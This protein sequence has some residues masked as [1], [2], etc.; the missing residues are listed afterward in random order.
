ME[1][2]QKQLKDTFN[3][4]IK[5]L[6]PQKNHTESS[7][8]GTKTIKG[9]QTII[10]AEDKFKWQSTKNIYRNLNLADINKTYN[11]I[12]ARYLMDF[13]SIS[14]PP[15]TDLFLK[16]IKTYTNMSLNHVGLAGCIWT[17]D[18]ILKWFETIYSVKCFILRPQ[19]PEE[20][21]VSY[22]VTDL[23]Y[24]PDT[25]VDLFKPRIEKVAPLGFIVIVF[26]GSH[27]ETLITPAINESLFFEVGSNLPELFY[28]LLKLDEKKWKH[29]QL[30]THKSII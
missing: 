8:S 14:S 27:Y 19:E 6:I 29:F 30:M 22:L 16:C 25:N 9:T 11:I 13:C 24:F 4:M 28:K 2:F 23:N 10:T 5:N 21:H 17:D 20:Y 18:N 1:T 7:P 12:V 15:K 26:S 3:G